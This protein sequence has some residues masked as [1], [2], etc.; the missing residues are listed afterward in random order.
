[1]AECEV[2]AAADR[3]DQMREEANRWHMFLRAR[4]TENAAGMKNGV[5]TADALVVVAGQ[6]AYAHG[7][8]DTALAV[9]RTDLAR[10]HLDW[11]VKAGQHFKDHPD[12]PG[13][14]A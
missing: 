10:K 5:L 2:P 1:M 11:M 13:A 12:Y 3:T 4:Y 14:R 8:L 6:A 9:G 7:C